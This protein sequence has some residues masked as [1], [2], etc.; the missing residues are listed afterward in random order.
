MNAAIATGNHDAC[1]AGIDL[2]SH[3]RFKIAGR[4]TGVV[5]DLNAT[6]AQ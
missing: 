3:L 2:P 4:L 5:L 6:L 1:R